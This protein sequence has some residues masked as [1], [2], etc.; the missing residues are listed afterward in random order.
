MVNGA[1]NM[2]FVGDRMAALK[3]GPA[4]V[5]SP[6]N[7]VCG[8]ETSLNVPG[9]PPRNGLP[10]TFTVN[11]RVFGVASQPHG[12]QLWNKPPALPSV[13]AES[14][15]PSPMSCQNPLLTPSVN[16]P[17]VTSKGS[18]CAVAALPRSA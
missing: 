11:M 12:L 18:A 14:E 8:Y 9:L 3:D 10:F 1:V 5:R 15:N 7:T 6:S 16:E 17:P 4:K 2:R 13:P